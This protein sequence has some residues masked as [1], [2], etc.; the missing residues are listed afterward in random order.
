MRQI[1]KFMIVAA[2]AVVA[3]SCE[4]NTIEESAPETTGAVLHVAD[5]STRVSFEDNEANGVKLAWET[6]DK[7]SL[8]YDYDGT[9]GSKVGD[10]TR[11]ADG[12]FTNSDVRLSLG[13]DYVAF[14]PTTTAT[15]RDA[16]KI[17]VEGCTSQQNDTTDGINT[18]DNCCAMSSVFQYDPDTAIDFDHLCAIMTL[19]YRY[20]KSGNVAT[21]LIYKDGDKT[22]TLTTSDQ[23]V[24]IGDVV[25]H[26]IMIDPV[27]PASERDIT[28]TLY[29]STTE[30]I[31]YTINTDKAF[32]AGKRYTIFQGFNYS[33]GKGTASAPYELSTAQD[34]ND[35]AKAV[36]NGE[37][38]A[39]RDFKLTDDITLNSYFTP[40]GGEEKSFNGKING[41]GN[42][43][44]GLN[45]GTESSKYQAL[46]GRTSGAQISDLTVKGSVKG[47]T[48]VAGIVASAG[49]QTKIAN[50]YSNVDVSAYGAN[51]DIIGGIVGLLEANSELNNSFNSGDIEIS[52][53]DDNAKQI[54]GLVGLA[55]LGHARFCYNR[56][57]VSF[58]DSNTHS[59][60]GAVIGYLKDGVVDYLYWNNEVC[61]LPHGVAM[62][63]TLALTNDKTILGRKTEKMTDGSLRDKFNEVN[64]SAKDWKDDYNDYPCLY[65]TDRVIIIPGDKSPGIID[66]K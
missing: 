18:L 55:D 61:D 23:G 65:L 62:T 9:D 41:N 54:G 52:A 53:T 57:A 25:T 30:I 46:F 47:N 58:T 1:A 48:Y 21:K 7:F 22:Y 13:E 60:T 37:N 11:Q 27:A 12:T 10:F 16:A 34:M 49:G 33:G 40:I 35:L 15:T 6:G 59:S 32:E 36:K 26:H 28:I 29:R 56:G 44:S 14:Y 63:K 50:C 42:T 66:K 51:V 19:K 38:Y 31:T 17:E 3:M 5:L 39:G 43:I 20:T 24:T 4:K 64:G 2:A 45:I 8:Y